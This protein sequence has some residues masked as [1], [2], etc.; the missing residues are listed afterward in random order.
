MAEINSSS[1]RKNYQQ[2]RLNGLKHFQRRFNRVYKMCCVY[3]ASKINVGNCID[4]ALFADKHQ[5]HRL[6]QS[7]LKYIDAHFEWIFTSDEFL[8]L[9]VNN[10]FKLIPLLVYNEMCKMDAV[11]AICLWINYRRPVRKPFKRALLK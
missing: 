10:L 8:E 6:S 2:H 4:M 3:L 9:P 7:A 11:N 1:I 5:F